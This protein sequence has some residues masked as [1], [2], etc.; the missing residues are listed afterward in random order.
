MKCL[1][2][3]GHA[4]RSVF[5]RSLVTHFTA[6]TL[7]APLEAGWEEVNKVALIPLW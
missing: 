4:I 1:I 3:Q 5:G 2:N 6:R 7:R